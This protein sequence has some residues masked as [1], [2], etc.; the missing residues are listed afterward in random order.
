MPQNFFGGAPSLSWSIPNPD[1]TSPQ[2]WLDNEQL[3]GVPLGGRIISVGE[4]TQQTEMGSG[5]PQ[6]WQEPKGDVPGRPKMSI[7]VV[8]RCDGTFGGRDLRNPENPTDTGD[9]TLYVPDFGDLNKAI[10]AAFV[11]AGRE[12]LIV[13]DAL[14]VAWLGYRPS[15]RQNMNPA[16]TFAAK[17]IL[18]PTGLAVPQDGQQ[19]PAGLTNPFSGNGTTGNPAQAPQDAQVSSNP[20]GGPSQQQQAAQPAPVGQ[21]ANPFA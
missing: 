15:K 4:P 13:G 18:A 2:R 17:Y 3:R 21:V 1:P 20:F 12:D 5:K 7:A 6:W 10:K 14:L 16:R 11:Q 9:R 8:L 19:D